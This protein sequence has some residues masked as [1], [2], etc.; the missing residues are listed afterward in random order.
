MNER[1]QSFRYL[2]NPCWIVSLVVYPINRFYLKP[3]HRRRSTN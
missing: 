1:A 3:H 2:V